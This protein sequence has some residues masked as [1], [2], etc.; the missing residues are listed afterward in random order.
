MRVSI[1]ERFA[2]A[3]YSDG[4]KSPIFYN[5]EVI[6]FGLQVRDNGRK[7][8]TIEGRRR[9]YFVGD[10]PAW[11]VAA[12]RDEARLIKREVD[13][14]TT[15]TT[16]ATIDGPLRP[17]PISFSATSTSTL[18]SRRRMPARTSAP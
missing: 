10:H 5:D 16:S 14:G 18:S 3:A 1:T 12:A 4:R 13:S 9:L 15:R 17:S 8:F 7:T 11:T 2:K 6:G